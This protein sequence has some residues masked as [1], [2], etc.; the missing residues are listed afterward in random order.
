[1]LTMSQ[2]TQ[3]REQIVAIAGSHGARNLR[4]FGSVAR[5]QAGPQSDLDVLVQMDNNR[6][7]LDR[8]ALMQDLE[9][10][11]KVSVD[12]VNEKAVPAAIRVRVEQEARPI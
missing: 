9:D 12:V 11:L 7:L 3:R 6:S 8:I 4:V 1:M 5:N 10:L 2:I